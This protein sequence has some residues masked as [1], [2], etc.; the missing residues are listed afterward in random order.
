MCYLKLEQKYNLLK[1]FSSSEGVV[2]YVKEIIKD[3]ELKD[4]AKFNST[5]MKKSFINANNFFSDLIINF[6]KSISKTETYK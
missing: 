3:E 5:V 2:E 6:P 1:H 4:N